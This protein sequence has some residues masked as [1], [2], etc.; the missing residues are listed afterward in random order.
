MVTEW[1]EILDKLKKRKKEKHYHPVC[2]P[3]GS[4]WRPPRGARP[5]V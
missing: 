3:P 4:S 5:P 2:A 1:W